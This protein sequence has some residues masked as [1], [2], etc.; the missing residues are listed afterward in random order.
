MK[1]L[2]SLAAAIALGTSLVGCAVTAPVNATGNTIGSKV[3]ESTTVG[4]LGIFHVDG[5]DASIQTAAKNGH[6]L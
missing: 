2:I 3:G 5:G 6:T 1:K 4:I